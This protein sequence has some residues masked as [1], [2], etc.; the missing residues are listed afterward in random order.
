MLADGMPAAQ[1][2]GY[3][4]LLPYLSGGETLDLACER[5]FYATC[6]YAKR[7][8][9]WFYKKDYIDWI[10]VDEVYR[11][12]VGMDEIVSRAETIALGV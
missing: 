9:T 10:A 8:A 2:I 12:T 1:A 11:G 6:R 5:L 7:Q 4:E 3:K